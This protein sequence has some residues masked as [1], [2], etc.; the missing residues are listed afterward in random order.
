[1]TPTRPNPWTV[2]ALMLCCAILVSTSFTVGKAI[3][4]DLDPACI[5]LFRFL[6]AGILF[7]PLVH[8]RHRIALPP[9]QSL[10]GYTL[11]SGTLVGFFYLMFLSLR[12]T[13][14]LHTGVIYTLVPSISGVYSAIILREHLGTTRILAIIPAMLGAIWVIFE[15]RPLQIF[16]L[17]LNKGDLIF[18]A[19]CLIMAL[20]TPLI[21]LFHKGEPMAVMTFWILICGCVWLTLLTGYDVLNLSW[22]NISYRVWFGIAYLSVFTTIITFFINQWATL[23]L[24]P[25]RVTAYSYLYP[26]LIVMIDWILGRGLPSMQT[27]LGILFILPAMF[28]LQKG[29]IDYR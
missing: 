1:M 12:Y 27:M 24:G 20:Y 14:A 16:T 26:P 3:A 11:I 5:T 21:R 19:G 29:E 28:I 4:A 23:H 18:L 2:H 8:H 17:D 6:L 13:T 7:M 9:V 15:G 22:R 10:L 25:T